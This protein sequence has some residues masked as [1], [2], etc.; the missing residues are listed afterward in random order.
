MSPGFTRDFQR[1]LLWHPWT[2]PP[3]Y[4]YGAV[5]LFGAPFQ[6][7]SR[8]SGWVYQGPQDHI[9]SGFPR[10]S[11]CPVPISI[12]STHGISFDFSSSAY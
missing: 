4:R 8:S 6:E 5:T 2:H 11:V 7:T 9:P 12:A 1:T 10:G 3:R